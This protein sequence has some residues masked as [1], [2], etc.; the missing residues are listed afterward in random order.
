MYPRDLYVH[1]ENNKHNIVLKNWSDRVFSLS[2]SK[3]HHRIDAMYINTSDITVS[4]WPCF[5]CENQYSMQ[6][7]YTYAQSVPSVHTDARTQCIMSVVI[8]K[9]AFYLQYFQQKHSFTVTKRHSKRLLE[10]FFFSILQSLQMAVNPIQSNQ[11][12]KHIQLHFIS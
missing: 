11:L 9:V 6:R 1:S 8:D 12:N 2:C 4:F 3:P 5:M 7:L 10:H